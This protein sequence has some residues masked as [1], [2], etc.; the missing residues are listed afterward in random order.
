MTRG[1]RNHKKKDKTADSPSPDVSSATENLERRNALRAK[2][3]QKCSEKRNGTSSDTEMAK[4]MISD[5]QGMLLQLG[6]EDP[7]VLSVASGI[8]KSA[9]QQARSGKLK[10]YKDNTTI[11]TILQDSLI[12]IG[13][14]TQEP[15]D[16][17]SDDDEEAPILL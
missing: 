16:D 15:Q 3:R 4:R 2:L 10:Q 5:P 9:T 8:V 1:G 14:E 6:I 11:Q 13:T 7:N 12:K 17:L